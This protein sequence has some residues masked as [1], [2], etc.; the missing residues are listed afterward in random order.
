M[1]QH[2]YGVRTAFATFA[3]SA[4]LAMSPAAAQTLRTNIISDPSMVDPITFSELIAGDV[5]GNVYEAFTRLDEDGNLV[6]A[7]AESWEAHDDNLGWRF[8]LRQGVKFHSGRDFTAKDVKWTFEQL[9][10]PGNKGGLN[11]EYLDAVV[12]AGAVKDGAA[13]NLEGVTIVDDYTVDVRFS[14]S[15]VLFPIYPIWFMDSGVVEEHGAD[16]P[17]KA[18]AG[19]GPFKFVEWNRGR[20]VRLDAH[21]DYWGE[22]PFID[23]VDFLVVPS[24]DTAIS[25]YEAG[26]LD[27][28][29]VS[30]VTEGRRILRDDQ[31]EE[32]LIKVPAAQIQYLGLN[33]TQYEPFKDKRVR[34]AVCIAIDRDGMVQ[35]LYGGAA[36]P[37]Y[38][39][40]TP[41]VAG[42]NPNLAPINYD[43][44]RAKQ[45]LAEAGF[46]NG[47]GLPPVKVTTTSAR[48]D[49]VAYYANQLKTVLGMPV[50][51]EIV[52][53]G[54]HIKNMN[55]GEVAFFPWGWTAGYPDANYFL[56]QVW[57]GPSV[58]NRSRWQNPEFDALIDQAQTIPDNNER[59]S[60][61]QQAEQVL[62]NDWGTCPTTVRMQ[63]AASKPNVDGAHLTP[64]RF[65]PF[66]EVKIK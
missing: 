58:Y 24:D 5:I 12:G 26:E 40:I 8:H 53:R 28:I 38:G 15:D 17:R 63:I 31:F 44:D 35:G 14:S 4:L 1:K 27:L 32:D 22:G 37:L 29:Y 43:P 39:Q 49:E 9:L 11:T 10:T 56:S 59:Y 21:E 30:S 25:M 65:I 45:L 34:E 50:E 33:Q 41:G 16:W 18:S 23:A 42:F 61:Y 66:N 2:R 20:N 47:A 7:L 48:K 19:T 54:S 46:P 64:F 60:V 51:V 57:F 6:P 13:A 55:A 3:V 36:F 62:L 52:E